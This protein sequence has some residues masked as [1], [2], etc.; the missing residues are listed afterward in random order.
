MSIG[1]NIHK[2]QLMKDGEITV[3]TK[4]NSL[5]IESKVVKIR[6]IISYESIEDIIII[7]VNETYDNQMIL[8]LSKP[9][10]YEN[11]GKHF[12]H[13]IFFHVY[14]L[15]HKNRLVIDISQNNDDLYLIIN[16]IKKN[17]LSKKMP[18]SLDRSLFW[19]EESNN[20]NLP[21]VKLIYSKNG[22]NLAEILKKYGKLIDI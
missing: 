2:K 13:K 16:E 8:Y 22:L 7:H 10:Q 19:E 5:V 15:F 1:K 14:L 17:L 3:Y 9:I 12:F 18:S 20:H 4:N 11:I 21:M 6:E